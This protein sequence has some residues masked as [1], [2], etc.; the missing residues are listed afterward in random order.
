MKIASVDI[1][2]VKATWRKGFNPVILRIN[3]DQG[4]SGLGE[5]GVAV[6][7]GHNAYLGI[8]RDLAEMHLIG[9]DP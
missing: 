2:D 4:L 9:A 1:Y 3:T 8:A 7:G 5:V 6:G